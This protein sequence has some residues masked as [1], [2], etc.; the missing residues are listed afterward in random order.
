MYLQ[1][2]KVEEKWTFKVFEEDKMMMHMQL[3]NLT[4]ELD[5]NPVFNV[6]DNYTYCIESNEELDYAEEATSWEITKEEKRI[7]WKG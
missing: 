2:I 6:S 4:K 5:T 7:N 3:I 1:K